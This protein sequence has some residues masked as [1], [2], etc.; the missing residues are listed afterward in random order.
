MLFIYLQINIDCELD[1]GNYFTY[2]VIWWSYV[3]GPGGKKGPRVGSM[4]LLGDGKN[5][6]LMVVKSVVPSISLNT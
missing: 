2:I 5:L 3:V 6:F 4:I 1:V